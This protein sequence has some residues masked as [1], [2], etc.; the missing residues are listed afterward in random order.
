MTKDVNTKVLPGFMELLP[1]EQVEFDK[2]K[3]TILKT[4]SSFGFSSIDTPAIERSEV[5]LAKAGGETEKQIYRFMKGDNDLSLRFDLTVPL[6]RYVAEHFN[7]LSFP[8]RRCH[9]AKVYR[10]ESPQKGRFR[11]FYQCDIDVIGKD[12]L[13]IRYDAEIPAIIYTLFS[14]LNFGK[15][16]IR[17]NNRKLLN[18]LFLNLGISKISVDVMRQ[19]DKIG[20]I[21]S[22]ELDKNLQEL[23][24]SAN[25]IQTLHQFF[26]IKGSCHEV[27]DSLKKQN[28]TDELYAAGLTELE[29][30]TR[31]ME[32]MGVH[33]GYFAI[34]LSIARGLD[35][36][37]GTVYETLLDDYPRLGSVC[38]GGRFDNLA[39]YYTDEQ[40]PGVG[41]SIG[42]TRLFYQLR[43]IGKIPCA[44]K[45]IADVIVVPIQNSQM[46]T[47]LKVADDLRTNG[48]NVD[49]LLEDIPQKKKFQYLNKK[50]APF[51]VV[52]DDNLPNNQYTLQHKSLDGKLIKTIGDIKQLIDTMNDYTLIQIDSTALNISLNQ[53]CLSQLYQA[54]FREPPYEEYINDDEIENIFRHYVD[55]GTVLVKYSNKN[56]NEIIAFC[57][58]I[59]LKADDDVYKFL[60]PYGYDD[61]YMYLADVGVS[62][63]FRRQGI[64]EELI[65]KGID[66]TR[67]NK[68]ILRTHVE[69][70]KAKNLYEKVRFKCIPDLTMQNARVRI[71]GEKNT[72]IFMELILGK[73][74]A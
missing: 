6:A 42:L 68:Y 71:D 1:E 37:T 40:L 73:K 50:D 41:I 60:Q 70:D 11:E 3:D 30:V 48:F 67:W 57:A 7:E 28:I 72:S 14:K 22:E 59:P 23:S 58:F 38:S 49:V 74:H 63:I 61:E 31:L 66:L 16:T 56:R 69:N 51:A 4:Y 12:S 43:E 18:G 19:I 29:T 25:Q 9:I 27:I 33:P 46:L 2:I 34:D 54:C 32:E 17:I 65:E 45:T 62:P 52:L 47:A 44:K 21:S 36:Y 53:R 15:F 24:L 55:S 20:K 64:A 10:G 26:D 39:S 5:L 13:S 8:F 35:Y